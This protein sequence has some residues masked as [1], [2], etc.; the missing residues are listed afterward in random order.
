MSA[1]L[2]ITVKQC[3]LELYSTMKYF[4]VV[5]QTVFET[6]ICL[7]NKTKLQLGEKQ[8]P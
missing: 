4:N 8:R 1:I 3:H 2:K 6:D 7:V 5:G